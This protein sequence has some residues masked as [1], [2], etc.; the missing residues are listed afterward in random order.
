MSAILQELLLSSKATSFKTP[1][2][3]AEHRIWRRQDARNLVNETV[4]H[5]IETLSNKLQNTRLKFVFHFQKWPEEICE[6]VLTQFYLT[7]A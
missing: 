1:R 5:I 3:W 7:I 4:C 2:L 6:V